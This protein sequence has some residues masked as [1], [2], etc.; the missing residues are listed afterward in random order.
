[1][2]E[3]RHAAARRPPA[4]RRA[5]SAARARASRGSRRATGV[6]VT[7]RSARDR[8]RRARSR[9]APA[10]SR[11]TSSP[12]SPGRRAATLDWTGDEAFA[13]GPG[14]RAARRDGALLG[15]AD[16]LRRRRPGAHLRRDRAGRVPRAGRRQR[17]HERDGALEPAR[18]RGASSARR[19]RRRARALAGARR[20]ARRRLRPRDAAS[21]SS[22]PASSSSSRSS[23]PTSRRGGRS[24]PTCCS[25]R[26]RRAGAQVREAG[27]R[28][29]APPPRPRRGRRRARS[30]PNLDFYEPR[31]AHGSSL[32]PAI[33]AA[34][35]RPRRA[36]PTRRSSCC[37][38][39]ARIDLD[40]L[41]G[42]TA[43]GLHLATMG[44]AL[45]GARV[46][47]RRHPTH[48]ATR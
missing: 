41:T 13:R 7:P 5:A 34:L 14:S 4:Q 24:P 21:T 10:S 40:D 37:G 45:A 11:S 30:C 17:V 1:M 2:L 31:T 12:T 3:Y 43:G 28:A 36:L 29:D 27:G 48:A 35:L 8:D 20:R 23:S 32:S 25:A 15:V 38:S 44:G 39:P 33:H 9:S 22:S 42:T 16:P 19:R 26:E 18:R 46:R 47:V 6:D